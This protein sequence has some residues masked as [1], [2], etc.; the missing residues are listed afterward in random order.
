MAQLPTLQGVHVRTIPD[1]LQVFYAVSQKKLPIISRR[2]DPEERKAIVPGNVYVW[3]ERSANS[4]AAGL[5]ME[6]WTDGMT[7]GMCLS[8]DSPHLALTLIS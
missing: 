1:A 6:R 7:W 5:T 2:L 8:S 4:D 3:E